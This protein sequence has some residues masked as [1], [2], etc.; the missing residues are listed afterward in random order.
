MR[1]SQLVFAD[2]VG[3]TVVEAFNTFKA[4]WRRYGWWLNDAPLHVKIDF[5]LQSCGS[6]GAAAAATYKKCGYG[7][8]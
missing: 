4:C 3:K 1:P 8:V 5:C 7:N 2:E 6:N